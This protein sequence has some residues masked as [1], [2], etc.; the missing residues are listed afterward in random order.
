M[1]TIRT[2]VLPA[3]LHLGPAALIVGDLARAQAFY[4]DVLGMQVRAS[5]ATTAEMGTAARP[6]LHL[7]EVRGATP[8]RTP[9]TGLYHV[10]IRVPARADL[11]RLLIQL[12]RA[13]YPLEGFADHHVSEAVYLAD[14]DGN[15][16]ELYRDRPRET[17]RWQETQVAMTTRPLDVDGIIGDV[18]DPDAPFAGIAAGADIG[19]VHLRVG[20]LNQ[21]R[22]FYVETLGFEV[23]ARLSSALFVSAGRYHHH[24]ALNTWQSAG[25]PP[26]APHHTGLAW[27]SLVLP[28][29]DA[30]AA[31]ADRLRAAGIA[32]TSE[33][34]TLRF[35]DPWGMGIVVTG[36]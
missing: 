15:G 20:D 36:G 19:H 26:P 11:G 16:L 18:P 10:A 3:T 35:T 27:Y 33:G 34:E 25:A 29:A 21:A 7:H 4:R 6:L 9:H 24:L 8:P 14:P 23:V 22:A 5:S 1:T 17:W 28:E 12:A 13:Q 32:H 2:P 31:L 30:H